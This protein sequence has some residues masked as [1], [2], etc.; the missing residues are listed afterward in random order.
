MCRILRNSHVSSVF[1]GVI[2]LI[3]STD[4]TTSENDCEE[5]QL[6]IEIGELKHLLKKCEKELQEYDWQVLHKGTAEEALHV[7]LEILWL[8]LVK[9][10]PRRQLDIVKRSHPWMNDKNKRAIVEKNKAE[11]TPG[12]KAASVKCAATLAEERGKHVQKVKEKMAT[13]PPASKQWW[14]INR[15]LLR[16]KATLSSMPTLRENGQWIKDAKDKA[17]AFA[18]NFKSKAQLPEELVDIHFVWICRR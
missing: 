1:A 18:R 2:L 3:L 12:F 13:L 5:C 6:N 16:R 17:D 10:I 14:K 7:F 4:L 8:H 11:G 9:H 15:E